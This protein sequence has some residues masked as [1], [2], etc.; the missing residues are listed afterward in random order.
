MRQPCV[1]RALSE[2]VVEGRLLCSQSPLPAKPVLPRARAFHLRPHRPSS[3]PLPA[4]RQHKTV[5][6]GGK[7]RR[8][9]QTAHGDAHTKPCSHK[10]LL[11]KAMRAR[12]GGNPGSNPGGARHS[13]RDAHNSDA[14]SFYS[15]VKR[16][17]SSSA[18]PSGPW[19][20]RCLPS[21]SARALWHC[22]RHQ[23]GQRQGG[24]ARGHRQ[25]SGRLRAAMCHNVRVWMMV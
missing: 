18:P 17:S 12:P 16:G 14:R 8:Q 13:Q 20:A 19:P 24:A 10:A 1:Q 2:H 25:R 7:T 9:D 23:T 22:V 21:T 6:P 15:N 5:T 4:R 11:T 3:G